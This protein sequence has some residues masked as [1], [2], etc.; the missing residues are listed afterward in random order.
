[1][2]VLFKIKIKIKTNSPSEW[3]MGLWFTPNS[4]V[5]PPVNSIAQKNL[6]SLKHWCSESEKPVF[7]MRLPLICK[8]GWLSIALGFLE[9]VHVLRMVLFAPWAQRKAGI[10]MWAWF[11]SF[12][13][14][15]DRCL[16][17]L[18]NGSC[19]L[20]WVMCFAMG[21]AVSWVGEL[22]HIWKVLGCRE[23]LGVGLRGTAMKTLFLD[24]TLHMNQDH[25]FLFLCF[26]S[27]SSL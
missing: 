10:L 25:Y 23:G 4:S 27:M 16:W 5:Y 8:T 14:E 17:A 21:H 11:G 26:A 7:R 13:T 24:L 2:S 18:C 19:V 22:N 9:K 1:M 12:L 6:T 15:P 20:Q 3:D